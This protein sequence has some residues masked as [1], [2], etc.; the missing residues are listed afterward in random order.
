MEFLWK[1]NSSV[2]IVWYCPKPNENVLPSLTAHGKPD[3]YEEAHKKPVDIE[4]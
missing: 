3:V 4:F 2:T 1:I